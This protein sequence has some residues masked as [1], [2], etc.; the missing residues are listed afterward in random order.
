M[1]RGNQLSTSHPL[2]TVAWQFRTV[3]YRLACAA[4]GSNTTLDMQIFQRSFVLCSNR[5]DRHSVCLRGGS[6]QV[7]DGV[8]KIPYF[9]GNK[10]YCF[11]NEYNLFVIF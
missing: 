7:S 5:V 8:S 11:Q 9:K 10:L 6:C 3:F 4:T 2:I 1:F